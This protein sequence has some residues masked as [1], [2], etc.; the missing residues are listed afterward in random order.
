METSVNLGLSMSF[1]RNK[2]IA[3]GIILSGIVIL[4]S[5]GFLMNISPESQ[6]ELFIAIHC[7]PGS[8]PATTDYPEQYW[9]NLRDMMIK[10]DQYDVKLTL[11]FNPQWASYILLDSVRFSMVRSWESNGH[12]IGLH[13]HGAHMGNWNGYTDQVAYQSDPKYIGSISDM[14]GVMNQIPLSGTINVACVA[15]DDDIDIDFPIDI[16][17]RTYGGSEKINHLWSNPENYTYNNHNILGVTHARFGA[18]STEVNIDL[19]EFKVLFTQSNNEIAMGLVWHVF[20]YADSSEPFVSLFE[21]LDE[22]NIV[23][24]TVSNIIESV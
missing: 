3:L 5:I 12:E 21:Y 8:F 20:N 14:M 9:L 22:Q 13:H 23:T 6:P 11:L 1:G 18:V 24:Y 10:A 4:A 16:P 19:D 17:Y 15:N 7:E 2:T